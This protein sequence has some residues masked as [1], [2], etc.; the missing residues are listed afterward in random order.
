MER[1]GGRERE[2]E[3]ETE[4]QEAK[5][6]ENKEKEEEEEVNENE[7]ENLLSAHFFEFFSTSDEIR[8]HLPSV[9]YLLRRKL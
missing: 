2:R 6:D 7:D 5:K 1:E 8:Y 3:S 9:V 4:R